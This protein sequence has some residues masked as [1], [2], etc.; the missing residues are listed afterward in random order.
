MPHLEAGKYA[1]YVWPAYGA[2]AL[3]ILGLVADTLLRARRW[4]RAAE[5]K[6]A[7]RSGG[8]TP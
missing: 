1:V 4:R 2:S 5:R 8:E 3:V 6:R 7:A